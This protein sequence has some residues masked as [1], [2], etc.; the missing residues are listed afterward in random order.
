MEIPRSVLDECT[1]KLNAISTAAQGLVMNALSNAE[2]ATVTELREIMCEVM[3]QICMTVA[4][5]AAVVASDMYDDIREISTGK[6]LGTLPADTYDGEATKGAVR[7]LIQSV[8]ETGAVE[9][10]GRGLSERVDYEIK[11]AAG[12]AVINQAKRDPLK[13]R[14]ARIPSGVETCMFC[15][16]LASRGFVYTSADAA[17]ADGHYHPNCDCRI[18]PGFK[19][20]DVQGYDPEGLYARYMDCVDTLDD[21]GLYRQYKTLSDEHRVRINFDEYKTKQILAEMRTRDPLWLNKGIAPSITYETKE[22]EWII[23]H[24]RPHEITTAKRVSAHGI[25]PDFVYDEKIITDAATGQK[26][27]IGLA[28]FK[29]GT[30]IKTLFDASTFNTLDGYIKNASR[31]AN[32]KRLIFDNTDNEAASD[33]QIEGYLE[34][35]RRFRK[36]SIYLLC[37][38][39]KLKKIHRAA[40]AS[41]KG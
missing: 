2:W 37:K 23:K 12:D 31:K 5:D 20:M 40:Q 13:P 27:K 30:E 16:M 36:G 35:S 41:P 21:D 39:G 14:F 29:D 22:L 10:F 11:K 8:V 26:R 15:L 25:S 1:A 28:D 9:R 18:V 32:A 7:A 19:G 6:R 3:E 34:R 33:I 38:N 17:G 4:D 24:E